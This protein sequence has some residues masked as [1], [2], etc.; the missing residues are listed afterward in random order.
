MPRFFFDIRDDKGT[1]R[2][3]EGFEL[4]DLSMVREKAQR[5]LP[6]IARSEIPGDGDQHVYTVLVTDEDGHAVYSATLTYAGLWLL[7]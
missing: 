7:R 6:D 3:E 2:D 4:A 5:L 1:Q